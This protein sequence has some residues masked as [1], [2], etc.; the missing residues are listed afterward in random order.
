VSKEAT[1]SRLESARDAIIDTDPDCHQ[2]K[3][4]MTIKMAATNTD[5]LVARRVRTAD[6]SK[7]RPGV[8]EACDPDMASSYRLAL[9]DYSA[10]DSQLGRRRT[11]RAPSP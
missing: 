5:R 9:T 10:N 2:A 4:L 1:R 6:C 8:E 3:P 7:L 11:C